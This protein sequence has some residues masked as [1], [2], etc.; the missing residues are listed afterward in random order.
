M[1]DSRANYSISCFRGCR[2]RLAL[3]S[4]FVSTGVCAANEIHFC[5]RTASCNLPPFPGS[6]IHFMTS[7][8]FFG[9]HSLHIIH[10]V[11]VTYIITNRNQL[12]CCCISRNCSCNQTFDAF[13]VLSSPTISNGFW[14]TVIFHSFRPLF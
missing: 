11:F 13:L 2:A 14:A 8:N 6:R 5:C 4:V 9:N 7:K 10:I 12:T 3:L 1:S